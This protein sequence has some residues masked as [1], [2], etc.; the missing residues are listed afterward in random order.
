VR[1]DPRPRDLVTARVA[2]ANQLRAQ[3][4]RFW[5][6]PVRMF[7]AIDTPVSLAFLAK[8]PSPPDAQALG[9]KRLT[10]FLKTHGS[11]KANAA[12][13]LWDGYATPR[14]DVSARPKLHVDGRSC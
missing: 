3:L 14:P 8:Y 1:F 5:P 13:Q 10:A 2:M 6:G 7:S 4:E 11:S 9:V 12:T